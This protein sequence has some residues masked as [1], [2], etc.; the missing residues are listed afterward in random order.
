[1]EASLGGKE[2]G[3]APR[4][5]AAWAGRSVSVGII[6]GSEVHIQNSD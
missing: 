2:S 5:S 3:G 6:L 1:M 4:Q